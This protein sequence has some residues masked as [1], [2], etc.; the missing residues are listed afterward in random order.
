MEDVV[1]YTPP[2]GVLGRIANA[3]IVRG[4]L[5]RIF[6]YRAQ[7]IRLRFGAAGTHRRAA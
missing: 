1:H 2:L 3:T 7:A 4:M 6:A 5:R